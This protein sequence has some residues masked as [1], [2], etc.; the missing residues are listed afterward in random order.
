[1]PTPRV[2]STKRFRLTP[3]LRSQI[4]AAV[5]SGGYAHIAA[6][7]FG[8]PKSVF[9]D[10]MKR[11]GERD[12][13]EPYASFARDIRQSHAQARLRAEMSLFEAEPKLWLIHGPGRETD[14]SPGWSVSVKPAELASATRNVLLD[15]ELMALF[16]TLME[17]LRPYPEACSQVAQTLMNSGMKP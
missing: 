17:V 11:G 4:I 14:A 15:P 7:A 10:W 6:E 16:R 1:M 3:E 8:V 9:D 13:R 2:T 5:R 12:A